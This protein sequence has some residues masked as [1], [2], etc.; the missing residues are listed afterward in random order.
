M[1]S[2]TTVHNCAKRKK[3]PFS[4]HRLPPCSTRRGPTEQALTMLCSIELSRAEHLCTDCPLH[5]QLCRPQHGVRNILQEHPA[6]LSSSA[7][8][9]V[10]VGKER[11]I[12]EEDCKHAQVTRSWGVEKHIYH[13]NCC[14]ALC[15][16]QVEHLC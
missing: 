11:K 15:V 16:E 6:A 10:F 5:W 13:T 7:S 2:Y 3:P 14:L 8:V 12:G 9:L 1:S 4:A